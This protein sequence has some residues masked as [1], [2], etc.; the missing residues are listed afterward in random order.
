M[1]IVVPVVFSLLVGVGLY[2]GLGAGASTTALAALAFATLLIGAVKP[3]KKAILKASAIIALLCSLPAITRGI[4]NITDRKNAA[5][6]D[7][8]P[9]SVQPSLEWSGPLGIGQSGAFTVPLRSGYSRLSIQ[10]DVQDANLYGPICST[11][12]ELAVATGPANNP[13]LV[14]ELKPGDWS[15]GITLTGF[16]GTARV[17]V[18]VGTT[19]I[20]Q[21]NCP[22]DITVPAVILTSS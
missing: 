18:T 15:I 3:Q 21:R 7:P 19:L 22:V 16:T 14:G 1:Q 10:F 11:N 6:V 12:T 17:Q 4:V 9:V 20:G 8:Q 5:N 2:Y 13:D